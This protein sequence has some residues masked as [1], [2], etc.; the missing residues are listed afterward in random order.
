MPGIFLSTVHREEA[1]MIP[2]ES[3]RE[4]PRKKIVIRYVFL[5]LLL[6][7]I[8][9]FL[10]GWNATPTKVFDVP[11][12]YADFIGREKE[13][14]YLKEKL[15]KKREGREINL[16]AICGE[17]GIGKTELATAFSN[18]HINVFSCIAWI[19]GSS[20]EAVM[21]SYAGL[22]DVLEIQEQHPIRLREKI[23]RKLENLG[24]KPWLLI[25]DDLRTAPSDLPK[26]GGSVLMTCRDKSL[27]PSDSVLELEKN[28][29]EAALLFSKLTGEEESESMEKLVERLDCLPLMI[30]LA[31]HYIAETPGMS[32]DNYADIIW[33]VMETEESPL[34]K[35][36]FRKRYPRSLAASYLITLKLL[37]EKHPL[38][39][40]F[41]KQIKSL[42]FKNIPEDFVT[43][44]L[45]EKNQFTSAQ[46]T[47]L[48]GDI[49][50]EL[51]NHSLIRYDSKRGDFSIHQLLHQ[52][53]I[54][55]FKE[56]VQ[57]L[58][59]VL[60][61]YDP[62][63][64]YNPT[65]KETIRPFQKI[66]PHC[67]AILNQIEDAD[68]S[69]VRL[70]LTVARYFVETEHH[71]K[72]G[73]IYLDLAEEWTRGWK[74][75]V[76]GRIAFLQGIL[77]FR[78]AELSNE[79]KES[80]LL[81]LG[82]FTEALAIFRRENNDENYQ[83]I[84]QNAAK[85]TK[86]YQRAIC[87]QYQG[88]MMRLLGRLTEAEKAFGEAV[89]AFQTIGGGKDHFDIA[90]ILREQALILWE[91]SQQGMAI[92]KLEEAMGMQERVYG[93]EYLFQPTVAAT[94]RILGDFLFQRG[95][96]L[97]SD[98][99]YQKAIIVNQSIYQTKVHPYLADLH[100]L[101]SKVLF[102]LGEKDLGEKM[103]KESQ[104]IQTLLKDMR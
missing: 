46:I 19:D 22:G 20:E 86:E 101:R 60:T 41:L 33:S 62:I 82:H 97:K 27:C 74:H 13:R 63:C 73:K 71:L 5:L 12:K 84:E 61:K 77:Q 52:T 85:C 31:G 54:L 26:A 10:R 80:Y 69:S 99:A 87:I 90:R 43:C 70:A 95:E 103:E 45:E 48:K 6:L 91:R 32:I 9:L 58:F 1:P 79:K 11:S 83:G 34:R 42:H 2:H 38:S 14:D 21:H 55:E 47:L 39:W 100:H 25:I 59:H 35:V 56:E 50:R 29:Q 64:S 66:L 30:N 89:E 8:P 51:E 75:P 72:K 15:L 16:A 92:Q 40:E 53:L 78:E 76:R 57:D 4:E 24:G 68:A 88:Q 65:H 104:K 18:E 102:A 17:G 3:S 98:Q 67:M 36:E 44:W 23:H 7:L 93:K 28:P 96:F 81:A 37:E 94:Y 49:L